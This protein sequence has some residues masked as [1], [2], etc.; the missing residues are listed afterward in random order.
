M[1]TARTNRWLARRAGRAMPG[2]VLAS[3]A[4]AIMGATLAWHAGAQAA[5]ARAE[6][7]APP[8]IAVIDVQRVVNSLNELETKFEQYQLVLNERRAQIEQLRT[9]MQAKEREVEEVASEQ[10][11]AAILVEIFELN[12][13]LEARLRA[14]NEVGDFERGQIFAE[15]YKKILDRVEAF[16]Q[17]EGFDMVI[18]DDSRLTMPRTVN[19]NT[20]QQLI[21]NRTVLYRTETLDATDRIIAEMNAAY[22]A[23]N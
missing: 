20:V 12:A 17:R 22:Q 7:A 19:V 10:Q 14:L 1:Q 18:F 8:R 4:L 9:R 6:F 11:R 15:A 2:V 16:A 13:Q 5:S 21:R 3:A 23:G